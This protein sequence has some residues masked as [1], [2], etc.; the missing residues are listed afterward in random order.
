M[1]KEFTHTFPDEEPSDIKMDFPELQDLDPIQHFDKILPKG[2]TAEDLKVDIVSTV[3]SRN[4]F[5]TIKKKFHLNDNFKLKSDD[6]LGKIA[7]VYEELG[8]ILHHFGTFLKK[9]S[10]DESVVPY[11]EHHTCKMFIKGK[12]IRFGFK[13]G[14][15]CS[16]SGYLHVMGIYSGRKNE[17]SSGMNLGEDVVTQLL[18][19]IAD[20]SRHEIYFHNFFTSYN[21][22]K[23]L[24]DSR[25]RATGTVRSK[26]I[27]ECPL[28]DNKTLTKETTGA[29]DYNSNGTAFICH[30]NDNAI[31]TVTSNHQTYEPISFTK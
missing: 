16:S 19:K 27:R 31:V 12:P 11:Y 28:L 15:L 4:H 3:M 20:L 18:S 13:I 7:P 9:L 21:F 24:A 17:S 1:R 25:I 30:W 8:E 26:R 5:H 29:I 6:K 22:L 10:I 2:S 23:K 14:M